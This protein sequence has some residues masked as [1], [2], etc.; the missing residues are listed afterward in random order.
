MAAVDP[1]ESAALLIRTINYGLGAFDDFEIRW[2]REQRSFRLISRDICKLE[3]L[4]AHA[5]ITSLAIDDG[6]EIGRSPDL[7]DDGNRLLITDLP[8]GD[9]P[10]GAYSSYKDAFHRLRTEIFRR[11]LC[12][13]GLTRYFAAGNHV[14]GRWRRYFGILENFLAWLAGFA[15]L[16]MRRCRCRPCYPYYGFF[17]RRLSRS[18][19]HGLRN[20]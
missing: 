8:R 12:L 11:D 18:T 20:N 4:L 10:R 7:G 16:R 1:M 14:H 5:G 3:D 17:V 9:R 15:C 13:L 6:L 19:I 2:H